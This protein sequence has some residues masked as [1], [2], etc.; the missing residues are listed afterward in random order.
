MR[1]QNCLGT[2]F[3]PEP[4]G[5]ASYQMDS[6]SLSRVPSGGLSR[7]EGG[8]FAAVAQPF[9]ISYRS[10]IPRT[11]ECENVFSTFALS[12]SHVAFAS[13]R[14]EP[15]FMITSQSAATAA[16]F[17]I[18]D[19]VS[20]QQLNYAKL[21]AQLRADGQLL[22]WVGGTLTTNG[23]IVDNGQP[24]TSR[25]GSWS[26]GANPGSWPLNPPTDYFHDQN[27]GKGSK[28]IRYTPNFPFN[29]IYD[30]YTWF[31]SHANRGTNVPYDIVH[32]AGTNRVLVN[33]SVNASQWVFLLRTNFIAVQGQGVIIRNDGTFRDSANGFVIADA[34]RFMPAAPFSVPPPIVQVV[35]SDP[36]GD[37]RGTNRARFTLV[38]SGDFTAGLSVNYTLGGTASNGVDYSTLPGALNFP[39]GSN[40]VAL[41]IAPLT[42]GLV[43]GDETVTVALQ[44]GASYQLGAL[45]N[46]TALLRDAE[47]LPPRLSLIPSTDGSLIFEFEAAADRSYVLQV[48]KTLFPTFWTELAAVP[49]A[50]TAR[51]IRLTNAPPANAAGGFYRLVTP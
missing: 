3:A 36:R 49:A 43:E 22:D 31:V 14:M 2:Q 39:A 9:P 47:T 18:D 45:T 25:S 40:S 6:H 19:N 10:I 26:T 1:Q 21:A 12:A 37:E 24:G 32:A 20:V 38:R 4:I 8:L 46:A 50:A 42:D 15:V 29:G 34:V 48:S 44:A 28:F 16:A 41:L 17:A 23:V 5:L 7:S 11:G 51:T 13:C 35:A 30:V 33:Q 27:S